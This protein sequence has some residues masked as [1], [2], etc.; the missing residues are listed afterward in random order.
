MV[1]LRICI[2]ISSASV[3]GSQSQNVDIVALSTPMSKPP[4][5]AS[6]GIDG[7]HPYLSMSPC[8]SLL[9]LWDASREGAAGSEARPAFRAYKCRPPSV[10]YLRDGSQLEQVDV[11]EGVVCCTDLQMRDIGLGCM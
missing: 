3:R 7:L 2:H 10:R 4:V 9:P 11:E 5:E 1:Y 6:S 8:I